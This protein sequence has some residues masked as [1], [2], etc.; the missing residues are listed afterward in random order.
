MGKWK[1]E[2]FDSAGH[3]VKGQIEAETKKEVRKLLRSRGIRVKRIMM[4]SILEFDLGEWMVKNGY[5]KSFGTKEMMGMTKRLA[6]MINAGI[7]ILQ[8]LEL[9]YNQEKHPVLKESLRRIASDVGEGSPLADAMEKQRGFSDLYC[10]LVR[11]GEAG[12]ILDGILEKLAEHLEKQEKTKSQIK[13][14]MMYPILVVV[15]GVAIVG[16]MLVFVVPQFQEMI[17]SS[18][19]EIP[20]ATQVVIDAS[21][22]LQNNIMWVLL[23]IVGFVVIIKAI[24]S[25]DEGKKFFDLMYMK[26]PVFGGIIL[27]GNLSSFT[28]T[29]AT[30]LNAG[31]SLIDSLRICE[32]TI[33]N[34]VVKEDVK[35]LRKGVTQGKT[36]TDQILK[37]EYFPPMVG[38]MIKVGEQTGGLDQM[39][40]KVADVFEQEVNDLVSGMT[41][42]IEPF[43]LV[44]LGGA[45]G[46]ILI[47]MY[48]PI[49]QAAG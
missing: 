45:V 36:L 7:P 13:S 29:L 39:L 11:A 38:Q 12:G 6:V 19:Q 16:L 34:T 22:F 37:I 31:V 30:M 23:G 28:R 24:K 20:W 4:P 3:K 14:A 41:K 49:F 35:S 33:S 8:C 17:L 48:L 27:K 21:E 32:N 42:M 18:G 44:V 2:G 43:I 46:F 26:M 10:N 40:L 25:T 47:A 1:W 5:A 9:L 15:I